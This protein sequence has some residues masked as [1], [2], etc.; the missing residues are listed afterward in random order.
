[1][2]KRYFFVLS[3]FSLPALVF[4]FT[5][6]TTCK[7]KPVSYEPT[8]SIDSAQKKTL[9]FGVATQAFYELNTPLTKYLNEHLE[10]AH[11][12]IVA[13]SSFSEYVEKV[14][15]RYFDVAGGN[16]IIALESIHNGYS[17]LTA[18]VDQDVNAGVILVNKDSS[19]NHFSDLKGKSV[20][21]VE[22]PA[23]G[24]LLPMVYLYKNGLDVNKQI[25]LKYLESFESVILNIYL[26]RCSAGLTTVNGWHNFL[27]RRPEIASKVALRW[28]TPEVAGNVLLIR[29]TVD[30]KTASQLKKLLLTMHMNEQGRKALANLGYAKFVAA[31]S[32]T[33]LPFRNLLKE[34]RAIIADPKK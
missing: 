2:M 21:S 1:M 33:Y 23:L 5:L 34:Y 26:G 18:V 29:N 17:I 10:D 4:S 12:K 7:P 28:V 3:P 24:H 22:S 14:K 19:I 11:L 20:A 15:N 25:K 8:F 13:N 6:F 30:K 9:L 27:K 32:T 31:D 16:G